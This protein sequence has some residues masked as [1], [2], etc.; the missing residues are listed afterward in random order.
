MARKTASRLQKRRE[1]E[2]AAGAEPAAGKKTAKRK[3]TKRASRAK[4]KPTQRKRLLWAVLS[5]NMK[6]EARFSY[7]QR[8][9]AEE[10][11]E[12]LRA[13]SKKLYFIQPIK[14]P[15]TDAPAPAEPEEVAAA[16]DEE[17]EARREEE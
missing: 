5:G 10:K 4:E 13:K 6:E 12:A 15:I 9:A 17:P 16:S 11:L 8:A 3:P 1:I 14:E 2:A 7:E